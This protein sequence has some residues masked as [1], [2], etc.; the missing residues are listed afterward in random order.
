LIKKTKENRK[1]IKEIISKAE[2]PV[3]EDMAIEFSQSDSAGCTTCIHHSRNQVYS[4]DD[5]LNSNS[6][7]TS[8]NLA[9]R[10]F[11]QKERFR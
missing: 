11:I 4:S 5:S 1:Q 9:N 6:I 3:K 2:A 10:E 8:E 7:D